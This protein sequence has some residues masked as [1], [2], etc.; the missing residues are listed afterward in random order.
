MKMPASNENS[1]IIALH[2]TTT[3]WEVYYMPGEIP[4]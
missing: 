4:A 1:K 3:R 2:I